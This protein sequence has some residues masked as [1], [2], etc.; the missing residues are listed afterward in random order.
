M[1]P[2]GKMHEYKVAQFKYLKGVALRDILYM[3]ECSFIRK[4]VVVFVKFRQRC[5]QRVCKES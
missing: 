1:R 5:A 4:M 3:L 2:L